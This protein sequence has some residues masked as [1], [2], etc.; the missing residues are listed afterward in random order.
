M[1]RRVVITGMGVVSPLGCDLETFWRRLLA[2]AGGVAPI[3]RFDASGF[4]VRIAAQV[5]G[6]DPDRFVPPREQRRMD[7]Y[8][9]YALAAA[10]LALEDSGV[11]LGGLDPARAGVAISSGVG[12][13]ETLEEQARVLAG[14]GARRISPFTVP[15]MIVNMGAGLVAIEHNLQGPCYAVVTACATALHSIGFA[16]RAVRDGLC[17]LMVAGGAEACIT[18][19]GVGS[20]AAMRALSAR[21]DDPGRASRPFDRDR[22]GF[23]IGEGAGVVVLESLGRA[24]ARGARIHAEVAGFGMTCDAFHMTAP[25]EDGAGAGRAMLMAME[26][27]RL[28]PADIGYINAHGTST[29]L[30]DKIETLAIKRA[31][32]AEQARR[33]PVSS[34]KSMTGHMLGA[35]GGVETV[36]CALALQR[37]VIPPTANYETA[38]PDCDLDYVP[39]TPREAVI[40]ACLN[41]SFGFGGHNGCLALKRFA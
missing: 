20:F 34:S 27:A 13:L 30:N 1:D 33:V 11:D 38:D 37:G 2:C 3:D 29:P 25:R 5:R 41:N 12:G 18:P 26:E 36:V 10:R 32:G 28:A 35:A 39:N 9:W 31:L 16:A 40:G 22:D 21:N 15:A 23:V 6:F 17:D 7:R 24:V 19:L 8:C 4:G 14:K